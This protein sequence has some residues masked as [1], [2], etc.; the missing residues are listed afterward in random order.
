MEMEAPANNSNNI[1]NKLIII[2]NFCV[3]LFSDVHKLTALYNILQHFLSEKYPKR[4][5]QTAQ[6]VRLH[7]HA[8]IFTDSKSLLQ[9]VKCED[10]AQIGKLKNSIKKKKIRTDCVTCKIVFTS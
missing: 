7:S 1:I 4:V 6:S 9:T 2:H 8:I 3:T 5:S 10:G